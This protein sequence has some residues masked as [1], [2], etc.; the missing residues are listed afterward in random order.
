LRTDHDGLPSFVYPQFK[1]LEICYAE[2]K[3]LTQKTM[4]KKCSQCKAEKD[5]ALFAKNATRSDGLQ[6]Q[7]KPCQT[8]YGKARYQKQ[9]ARFYQRNKEH[10]IRN[11]LTVAEFLKDKACLDCGATN[12]VV[13]T[14]DHVRGKKVM[15]VSNMVKQSYGLQ[16]IFAEIAKCDIRCFNCHQ[17][18]DSLSKRGG[19]KWNALAQP[20]EQGSLNV[21]RL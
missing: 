21:S 3:P 8:I 5:T 9:K 15:E 7:C 19:M 12:P 18:K 20:R 11:Q 10:R 17:I 1:L 6:T 13:L 16:T 4:L 14:F 2:F